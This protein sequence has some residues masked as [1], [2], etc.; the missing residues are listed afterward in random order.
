[1]IDIGTQC[2]YELDGI[3]GH[4]VVIGYPKYSPAGEVVVLAT[5][6]AHGMPINEHWVTPQPGA[7]LDDAK[8]YRD[9]YRKLY[10]GFLAD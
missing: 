7:L 4:G 2:R 3:V 1:M 8:R 6:K 9:R 5:E 10:P